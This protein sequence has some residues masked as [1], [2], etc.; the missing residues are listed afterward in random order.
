MNSGKWGT[1]T[2]R[3]TEKVEKLIT[4]MVEEI[5]AEFERNLE[6]TD[7]ETLTMMGGYGRGEGGVVIID[8]EEKPHNN[9][10]FVLL[11]NNLSDSE[12]AA[13]KTTIM[14]NLQPIIAK[15]K[16]G[17]DL[18]ILSA[19]KLKK[20]SCRIIWYDMRFGHKTILGN[21]KFVPSLKRFTV[22]KIPDWDAR[23]LLVN[24]GT[25]MIIN[26]LL[27]EKDKLD[28]KFKKLIVKHI[29]KAIIGYGDTLLYF[30]DDYDWSYA[31]K[32]KRMRKRN[33]VDKEFK[34]I[35]D[36]AMNF[37]FQPKYDEFIK[38][39][40]AGWLADL[41]TH[42]E[43][44][45]LICEK[46]RLKR[47]DLDW[48]NYADTAFKFALTDEICKC[49]PFLKK[50]FYCLRSKP[51]P[52]KGNFTSRLGF[53]TLGDG[54]VLPILFPLFAYHLKNDYYKSIAAKFLGVQD[55]NFQN[56]RKAYL[57]FWGKTGDVNFI[58]TLTKYEI[59]LD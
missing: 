41:R 15:I 17:I 8:G 9:F 2:L 29:V 35:Y 24:R 51:Y 50:I 28:T 13:L 57:K 48:Q 53:R 22:A 25:L 31:E 14:K 20:A 5:A 7:Y 4:A 1:F 11:T 18:S 16:I 36:E 54:G 55:N 12:N 38:R 19:S 23:N 40:L 34:E 21:E 39:D 52:G 3:G 47:K 43:R 37:R 45:F 26:D 42:F 46:K 33:D 58:N 56:L 30:L 6:K 49:K 27:L 10:D 59:S 44:I 32:Q